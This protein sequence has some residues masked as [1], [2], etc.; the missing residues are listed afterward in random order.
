MTVYEY[1]VGQNPFAVSRES[2]FDTMYRIKKVVP[3]KLNNIRNDLPIDFCNII[4]QCL[5]KIPALRP[6]N[7]VALAKRIL[8]IKFGAGGRLLKGLNESILDGG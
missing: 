4:D 7:T 2:Q 3:K 8:E 1:A 6:A 5:K